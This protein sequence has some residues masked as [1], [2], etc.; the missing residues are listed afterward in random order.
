MGAV[1]RQ[2]W[3]SRPLLENIATASRARLA[4]YLPA[5]LELSPNRHLAFDEIDSARYDGPRALM[6]HRVELLPTL[7]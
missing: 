6:T 5:R 2:L 3:R 1:A 7:I 4:M